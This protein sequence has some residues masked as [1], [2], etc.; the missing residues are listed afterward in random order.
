MVF[1]AQKNISFY[2]HQVITHLLTLIVHA[3]CLHSIP[4]QPYQ[5]TDAEMRVFWHR[6]ANLAVI[7]AKCYIE[8]VERTQKVREI[9]ISI[10]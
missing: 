2:I 6:Y 4:Y 9:S 1:S 5:Q 7:I 10:R 3:A 8:Y